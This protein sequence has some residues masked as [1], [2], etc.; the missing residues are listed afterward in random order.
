[1]GK[2]K[3]RKNADVVWRP[4]GRQP[5]LSPLLF[6][7]PSSSEGSDDFSFL[8]IVSPLAATPPSTKAGPASATWSFLEMYGIQPDTP[9]KPIPA[10]IVEPKEQQPRSTL[11][12]PPMTAHVPAKPPTSPPKVPL[13][14]VPPQT[15]LPHADSSKAPSSS[16]F[17]RLPAPP[18]T[19]P[20]EETAPLSR[21]SVPALPSREILAGPHAN[22]ARIVSE[23]WTSAPS[24]TPSP[25]PRTPSVRSPPPAGP[26][27]KGFTPQTRRTLSRS[28]PRTLASRPPALNL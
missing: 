11:L 5:P 16:V 8:H 28:P 10:A 7:P 20:A 13:P 22:S 27:P 6:S 15:A 23:Q 21:A 14:P 26:R 9:R 25:G 3:A 12:Q 19:E 4:R 18:P 1:M 24:C 2:C 17:R